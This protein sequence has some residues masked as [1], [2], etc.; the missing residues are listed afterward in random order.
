MISI[1][2]VD[3]QSLF[4]AGLASIITRESEMEV[5]AEFSDGEAFLTSLDS[6]EQDPYDIILLDIS[7]PG[8]S[9]LEILAE[10]SSFGKELPP[11]C[12]LSMFPSSFYIEQVKKLGAQGYL[13]KNCS[14]HVLCHAITVI[15][16][17]GMYFP[18]ETIEAVNP[19][20]F[21]TLSERE[22][23]VFKLLTKGLT[24]KEIAYELQISVKSISTYKSRLMEKLGADSLSDLYKIVVV[25]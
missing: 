3:D 6:P 7:L 1:A 16:Q 13:S 12:I 22:M 21:S 14:E 10:L 2:L 24:I 4:R 25:C 18:E 8:K 5:A 19:S 11:I 9:G 17:G 20:L 23:E 15:A